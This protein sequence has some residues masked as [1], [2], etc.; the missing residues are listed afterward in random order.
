MEKKLK[1]IIK[2]FENDECG[3]ESWFMM[4]VEQHKEYYWACWGDCS[5]WAINP[6][7]KWANRKALSYRERIKAD[8]FQELIDLV[9]KRFIKS[10]Q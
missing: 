3:H 4:G 10:K 8:T 9:Y 6:F 5:D 2:F 1:K 7:E